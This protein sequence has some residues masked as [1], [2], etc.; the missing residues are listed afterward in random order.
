VARVTL[1]HGMTSYTEVAS[2]EIYQWPPS[3]FVPGVLERF[4][5]TDVYRELAAKQ[6][7]LIAPRGAEGRLANH[8]S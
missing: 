1:K 6:S 7:K 5:L 2:A 3:S 4:D 8:A